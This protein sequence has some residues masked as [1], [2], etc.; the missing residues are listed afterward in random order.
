MWFFFLSF[1]RYDYTNI[2]W[3]YYGIN[4]SSIFPLGIWANLINGLKSWSNSFSTSTR[5][6]KFL[7]VSLTYFRKAFRICILLPSPSIIG[8][9]LSYNSTSIS[10]YNHLKYNSKQP[11]YNLC[12]YRENSER[13]KSRIPYLKRN[14]GCWFFKDELQPPLKLCL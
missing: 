1:C 6:A 9:S 14:M 12:V 10:W 13:L 2:Y 8:N 3:I 11:L 5:P 7:M 4:R